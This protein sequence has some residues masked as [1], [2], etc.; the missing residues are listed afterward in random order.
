MFGDLEDM[1]VRMGAQWALGLGFRTTSVGYEGLVRKG[2]VS[3]AHLRSSRPRAQ[4]RTP[5]PRR[6]GLVGDRTGRRGL[7][8]ATVV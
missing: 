6:A 2:R 8:R 1:L 7:R 5:R 4:G 3:H